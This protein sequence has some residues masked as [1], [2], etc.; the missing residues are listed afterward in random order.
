MFATTLGEVHV[1]VPR[2]VSCLCTP[3]PL[4][5]NDDPVDL[6]DSECPMEHLL[7]KRRTTELAYLCA[8]YGPSN[9]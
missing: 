3:E 7:P 5:D 6:R 1:R 4:D 9:S 8:K 2:V